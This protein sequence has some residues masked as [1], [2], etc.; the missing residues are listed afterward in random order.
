MPFESLFISLSNAGPLGIFLLSVIT[1]A[2]ILFPIPIL[3]IALFASGSVNFLGLGI[4]SPLVFGFAAGIGAGFGE[5][6]GYFLGRGGRKILK[7]FKEKEAEKIFLFGKKLEKKGFF[8][9]IFFAFFPFPFDL[10]GIAAGLVKF[11]LKVFIIGCAIGKSFRYSIIAYAG[12]FGMS[13]LMGL[14]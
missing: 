12:Y 11:P 10:V 6:S 14:L 9:L 4:F 1:N 8:A 7:K 5:L 13:W 2:S 3:E